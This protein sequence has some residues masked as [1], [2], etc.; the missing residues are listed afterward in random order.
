MYVNSH[1]YLVN[2][3]YI[4]Q[5][6]R[7]GVEVDEA[8]RLLEIPNMEPVPV[9][10]K[11]VWHFMEQETPEEQLCWVAMNPGYQGKK[12][13]EGHYLDYLVDDVLSCDFIFK[14]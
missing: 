13:I 10:R 3:T 4:G 1:Y 11:P 8:R 12:L 6:F 14:K 7:D 2:Y 5:F 9:M